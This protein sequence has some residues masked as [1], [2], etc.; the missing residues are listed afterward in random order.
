MSRSNQTVTVVIPTKN[1]ERTIEQMIDS[2]K[3][4]AEEIIVVD[5]RSTDNTLD[6]A[7][8][9]GAGILVDQGR[10]KGNGLR[11][12]LAEARGEIVVFIDA[13]GSHDAKDIPRLVKPIADGRADLVIGSRML[14]GSDE[15]H[16][17]MSNWVR[18]VGS[19]ILTLA[20][21]YRWGVRLTD[22]ENGFRAVSCKVAQS[23]NLKSNGFEIEQE[24][25][26]KA[27]KKGYRVAEVPS[28]EYPR[29]F[30]K[31]RIQI[32]KVWHRFLWSLIRNLF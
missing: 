6:I 16:G 11:M 23:L 29:I 4:Y 15:F 12:A 27:L 18:T 26:M 20:I 17:D 31:S 32:W 2:V 9:A 14:G 30:G 13:D 8:Q 3:A 28:H 24:M 5:G 19:G 21:N 1:E 22:C 10:G 7:Q 25:V